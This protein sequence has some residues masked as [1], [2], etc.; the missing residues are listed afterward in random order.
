MHVGDSMKQLVIARHYTP[1]EEFWLSYKCRKCGLRF[2]TMG[3][4]QSHAKI[5][6]TPKPTIFI[7]KGKP[8]DAGKPVRT[9]ICSKCGK[10]GYTQLHHLQYHDDDPLRDTIELCAQCHGIWHKENTP[11]W[12]K[13]LVSNT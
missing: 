3:E 12:G 13:S 9:G 2:E 4:C 6:Q 5:H 8:M 11:N 7:Y 1:D 10:Q